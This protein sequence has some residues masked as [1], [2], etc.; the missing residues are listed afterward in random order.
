MTID[1]LILLSGALLLFITALPIPHGI[2]SILNA[3][4]GIF[5]I[6][7]GILVRRR[8]NPMFPPRHTEQSEAPVELPQN[9]HEEHSMD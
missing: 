6:V 8:D 4:L 7:L 2:V 9:A 1:A 5:I 3:L